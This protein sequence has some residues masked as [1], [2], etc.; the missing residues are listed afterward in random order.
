MSFKFI[1]ATCINRKKESNHIVI[2]GILNGRMSNINFEYI[3]LQDNFEN[4]IQ[5]ILHELN[6]KKFEEYDYFVN[7]MK[8]FTKPNTRFTKIEIISND[9]FQEHKTPL[10]KTSLLSHKV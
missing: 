6:I 3:F 8:V 10:Q 7:A 2:S 4:I 1:K 9:N 5:E